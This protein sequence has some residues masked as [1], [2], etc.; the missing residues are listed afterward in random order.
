MAS[1]VVLIISFQYF[2]TYMRKTDSLVDKIDIS[3]EDYTILVKD[4]PIV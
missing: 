2:R 3:P 4:I 1:V